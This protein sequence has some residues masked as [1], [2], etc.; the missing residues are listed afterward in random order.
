MLGNLVSKEQMQE[1]EVEIEDE[2][3]K[4]EEHQN[5][6]REV[7]GDG[8]GGIF[9]APR[10]PRGH[11]GSARDPNFAQNLAVVKSGGRPLGH[12]AVADCLTPNL[13]LEHKCMKCGIF[14]H[15]IC[16]EENEFYDGD[17]GDGIL[18][19]NFYCSHLC[20]FNANQEAIRR[21]KLRR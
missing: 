18:D 20:H 2:R 17:D 4:S 6:T 21:R 3:R 9:V 12:C 10:A 5:H 16:V 15:L 19:C 13:E 14:V 7:P 8:D 1:V 11:L